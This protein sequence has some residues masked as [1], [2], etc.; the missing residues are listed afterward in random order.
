[1]SATWPIPRTSDENA[2]ARLTYLDAG[3]VGILCVEGKGRLYH[4]RVV[5][6]ATVVGYF[7]IFDTAD[8]PVADDVPIYVAALPAATGTTADG[9]CVVELPFGIY[10]KLGIGIGVSSTRDTFTPAGAST[11]A[12][13]VQISGPGLSL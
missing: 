8:I 2:P 1:M 11:A 7:Q 5:G 10:C 4:A 12:I 3:D 9:E 13:T 6:D